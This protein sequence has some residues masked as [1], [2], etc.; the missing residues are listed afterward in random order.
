MTFTSTDMWTQLTK[1]SSTTSGPCTSSSRHGQQNNSQQAWAATLD[2]LQAKQ[3]P[4][5]T[6]KGPITDYSAQ[7]DLL[8]DRTV[9]TCSPGLTGTPTG[10]SK[11]GFQNNS[12]AT[13]KLGCRVQST[14]VMLRDQNHVPFVTSLPRQSMCYGCVN[15]TATNPISHSQRNGWSASQTQKK[16]PCGPKDGYHLNRK[17]IC[18]KATLTKATEFGK[19]CSPSD[20]TSMLALHSHWMPPPITTTPEVRSGY[21]A[22]ACTPKHWGN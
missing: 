22:S 11:T 19:S 6:V 13:C 8:E 7:T 2:S 12:R 4:W 15:G 9:N 16:K 1:S 10:A 14:L 20:Q 5:Y 21:S 18:S 3:H 17:S